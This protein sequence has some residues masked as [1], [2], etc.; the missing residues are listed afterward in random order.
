M[1]MD[2][3]VFVAW[4][5]TTADKYS[6]EAIKQAKEKNIILITGIQFAE[7]LLDAGFSGMNI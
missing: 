1:M 2:I 7:M 4:V 3:L 6:E 5:I